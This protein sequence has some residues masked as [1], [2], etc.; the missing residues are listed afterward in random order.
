MVFFQTRMLNN[1]CASLLRGGF[2]VNLE[3]G[4]SEVLLLSVLKMAYRVLI[5]QGKTTTFT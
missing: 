2:A 3:D 1:V 5:S 4:C